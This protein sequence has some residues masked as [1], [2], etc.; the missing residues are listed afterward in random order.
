MLKQILI[1]FMAL[2]IPLSL[3]AEKLVIVE[4]ISTEKTIFT[5]NEGIGDG[6]FYGQQSLFTSET[7]SLVC[8]AIKVT[9]YSSIWRPLDRNFA[10]PF[11][12]KQTISF[13]ENREGIYKE[14]PQLSL[15]FNRL[16]AIRKKKK[17]DNSGFHPI[18]FT[19]TFIDNLSEST[20]SVDNTKEIERIG[21]HVGL[22]YR[23]RAGEHLIYG[24]GLRIDNETLTQTSPAVS[25]QTKR[26][27]GVLALQY[28]FL[29]STV[30]RPYLFYMSL[31]VGAGIH[32]TIVSTTPTSGIAYILPQVAIGT[33]LNFSEDFS[34]VFELGVENIKLSSKFDNG[35]VQT[36]NTANITLTTGFV[37]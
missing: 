32:E 30:F 14:I 3:K 34:I 11:S 12:Q 36:T 33:E 6:I 10:V 20:T 21:T 23:R 22:T 1:I 35:E 37:F 7:Y 17:Q 15:E 27:F 29:P 9:R 8:T 13:N 24:L 28:N 25:I 5:I 18:S 31:S 19:Y 16:K 4:H 2:Q 26:Y